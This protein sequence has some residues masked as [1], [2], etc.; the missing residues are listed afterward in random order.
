MI[1][2][3]HKTDSGI[4]SHSREGKTLSYRQINIVPRSENNQDK[5]NNHSSIGFVLSESVLFFS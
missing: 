5:N 3:L 1:A 2:K 4:C